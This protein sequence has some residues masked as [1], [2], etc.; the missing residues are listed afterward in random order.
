MPSDFLNLPNR[1]G[2]QDELKKWP[3]I[4]LPI[5]R[6]RCLDSRKSSFCFYLSIQGGSIVPEQVRGEF[7]GQATLT[8]YF[9][10]MFEAKEYKIFKVVVGWIIINVVNLIAAILTYT[11]EQVCFKH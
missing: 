9:I 4:N 11:A 1:Y 6:Q 10:V 7:S 3:F 2:I 5:C 8:R